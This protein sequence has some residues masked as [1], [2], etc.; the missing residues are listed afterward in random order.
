MTI[1]QSAQ[2]QILAES[3]DLIYAECNYA[4]DS[5]NGKNLVFKAESREDGNILLRDMNIPDYGYL[6]VPGHAYAKRATLASDKYGPEH[7]LV[8]DFRPCRVAERV[9]TWENSERP[10]LGVDRKGNATFAKVS[11]D[12]PA[13]SE[14]WQVE[15][16]DASAA[17]KVA[18]PGTVEPKEE[19]GRDLTTPKTAIAAT[20][21]LDDDGWVY[22]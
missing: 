14:T 12:T 7:V 16:K 21:D 19:T 22:L 18:S 17:P 10:L 5:G 20:K 6:I 3:R 9:S 13:W 8:S 15:Y 4:L 2:R 1:K 11:D